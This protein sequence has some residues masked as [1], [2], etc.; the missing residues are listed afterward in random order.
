MTRFAR[1]LEWRAT[2]IGSRLRRFKARMLGVEIGAAFVGPDTRFDLGMHEGVRGTISIADQ[3]EFQCGAVLRAYGGRIRLCS[4]VFIGPY[5]AIYGHG[6]VEIGENSLL[7]MQC[8]VLSSNHEIPELGTDIRTFPDR[9][10]ATR[11]GRDVWLGAGVKVLAGVTIGDGCVV[12]A[13]AVVTSDI[14]P[15]AIAVGVPARVVR[16]RVRGK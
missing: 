8:C 6:G 9:R 12:G 2:Q 13:G 3:A 16:M 10:L 15:G 14:P 4:N 1:A 5:V 7:S 11:I